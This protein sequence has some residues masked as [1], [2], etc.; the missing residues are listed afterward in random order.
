MRSP[1]PLSQCI[2][3]LADKAC[4]VY[5]ER[6]RIDDATK[7]DLKD[8]VIKMLTFANS[9]RDHTPAISSNDVLP[10]PWAVSGRHKSRLWTLLTLF[11]DNLQITVESTPRNEQM[12]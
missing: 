11:G 12:R 7:A 10:F 3:H 8:L 4:A 1:C 5:I 2:S 9:H 6:N